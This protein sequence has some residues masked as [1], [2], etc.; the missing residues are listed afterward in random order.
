MNQQEALKVLSLEPGA[1]NN[2]I[3]TAVEKKKADLQ[4][5]ISS[6]PTEALKA[7]FQ[8]LLDKVAEAENTL[9]QPS[10]P[11]QSSSP[12]SETKMADLPGA[13]PAGA[14]SSAQAL[15]PGA[16]LMERYEIKALI[17]QGGMGAVYR[18]FDKNRGEDI[19]IKVMLPQLMQ[20]ETARERFLDEAR[21]SSQLSHPNIVNVY[22]VLQDGDLYFL[23]ME[24][25]E[26]QDLREL[27]NNR[28]LARQNFSVEE[29]VE[30][31]TP[32]CSALD[33]AHEVTVH[34]DIK[35]ENIFLTEDGK[36]K[37]M[38]FGIARVM[39]TSQR[40][41][42]G[43]ASG[44]A[45]Y[46][47][48]EQLK[49]AKAIDGR[50]DQ[51]ALAVLTYELLSGEVPAG[52]IE[53]LHELVKGINK[54]VSAA[55][56]KALSPK[57]ENR[58]DSLGEFLEA[59]KGKAG[60]KV[61]MPALPLKT[62]GIAAGVIAAIL[63][64][65]VL[66]QSGTLSDL[67]SFLPKSAEELAAQ[68]A[69]VAKLQGEIK[70]YKRRLENGR[71]QLDSDLRDASRNNSADEK[72]LEHWQTLTDNDIFNGSMMTELEGDAS[73]GESLLRDDNFEQANI[74]LTKVRDGYKNLWEQFNAAENI[75][76]TKES[77][78]NAKDRWL[79]RKTDYELSDPEQAIIAKKNEAQAENDQMDGNFSESLKVL[80]LAES[81]WNA[82]YDVVASDVASIDTKREEDKQKAYLAKKEKQR[83]AYLSKKKK[84]LSKI[85]SLKELK[86]F[87]KVNPDKVFKKWASGR[88]YF[89]LTKTENTHM[90]YND[91]NETAKSNT[92]YKYK[93]NNKG[94]LIKK[95][96][97]GKSCSEFKYYYNKN[98]VLQKKETYEAGVKTNTDSYTYN[99][100]GLLAKKVSAGKSGFYGD[101]SRSYNYEYD[102]KGRLIVKGRKY[103]ASG[104]YTQDNALFSTVDTY[105]KI[106]NLISQTSKHKSLVNEGDYFSD[107]TNVY[108]KYHN[109]THVS[110]K[111]Q[112]LSKIGKK[113][114]QDIRSIFKNT[115]NQIRV[116]FSLKE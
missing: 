92:E 17:A 98:G 94:D 6:A 107:T 74:T 56:Q 31:L 45:Y 14:D 111:G 70:T 112:G 105:D 5:K 100:R 85:V 27:M 108:D 97:V 51:Y 22:D 4:N 95:C 44:T 38:D 116:D 52:A 1:S 41:Q 13:G 63:L 82:A 93:Y 91:G 33:H 28:K 7:K 104:G 29:V 71:R 86:Y 99:K 50:A 37:L 65:V 25:L 80:K 53:P 47:A 64:L 69:E 79:K 42:T 30:I 113:Y 66:G 26:G 46:M 114:T 55:V 96:T 106:D 21:L 83:K 75:L 84:E 20:N 9:A 19:A 110:T 67:S 89:A 102:T 2:E 12:L 115:Y 24:L 36:Y 16:T 62:M 11:Q 81:N 76:A 90:I 23:T 34:R 3:K 8:Q 49:G 60:G 88:K 103:N 39:S 101:Y 57:P 72:A 58:F 77:M 68:K 54:K 59:I 43:A 10:A 48:P 18:A 109:L 32:I 15:Q 35:P 78:I 40:T 73:M 61:A 87:L